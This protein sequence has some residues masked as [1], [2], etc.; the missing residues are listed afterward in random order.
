MDSKFPFQALTFNL[1]T[2]IIH[3]HSCPSHSCS[4]QDT[5][6]CCHNDTEVARQ[7]FRASI[8]QEGCSLVLSDAMGRLVKLFLQDTHFPGVSIK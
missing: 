6:N 1:I 5:L 2:S 7:V 4:V 8:T 3:P